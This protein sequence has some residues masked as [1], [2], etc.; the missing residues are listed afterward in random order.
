MPYGSRNPLTKTSCCALPVCWGS[1][2][3]TTFPPAVSARNTSPLGAR[4]IH[5]GPLKSDAK[6]LILNPSGT[7]GRNPCGGFPSCAGFV[8]DLDANGGGRSGF[9]PLV[10]CARH[11][12]TLSTP[13]NKLTTSAGRERN[14]AILIL[15][16]N[17]AST[18]LFI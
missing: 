16:R 3:T 8:A 10:T 4:T 11:P 1:R 9:W 14:P 5:R 15:V 2:S 17:L 13:K 6:I 7:V 12:G 18:L